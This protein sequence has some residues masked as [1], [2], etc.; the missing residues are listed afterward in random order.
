MI[1][2]NLAFYN[3]NFFT[4]NNDNVNRKIKKFNALL[5][6]KIIIPKGHHA[7]SQLCNQF[8]RALRHGLCRKR[9]RS[10]TRGV[11][12]DRPAWQRGARTRLG[13]KTARGACAQLRCNARPNGKENDNDHRGQCA[14]SARFTLRLTAQ[15]C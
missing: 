7:A 2:L 10:F 13:L 5:R 1:K 3:C 11:G 4:I 15:F 8:G 12:R 14:Q 9:A 6:N